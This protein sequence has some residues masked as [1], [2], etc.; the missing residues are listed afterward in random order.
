LRE[1]SGGCEPADHPKLPVREVGAPVTR[2][3]SIDDGKSVRVIDSDGRNI[4]PTQ[5]GYRHF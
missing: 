4:A 3:D 2:I 5:I 1:K